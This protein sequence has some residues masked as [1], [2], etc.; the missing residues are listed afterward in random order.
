MRVRNVQASSP[1]LP[2][3]DSGFARGELMACKAVARNSRDKNP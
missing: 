2:R 3:A 1:I